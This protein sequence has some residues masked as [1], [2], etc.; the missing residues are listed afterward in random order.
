MLK[1]V[2]PSYPGRALLP[3]YLHLP[4][5]LF[6]YLQKGQLLIHY[7]RGRPSR[8]FKARSKTRSSSKARSSPNT[9]SGSNASGVRLRESRL[10][11][12][13][14]RRRSRR[15]Q[16]GMRALPQV[17]AHEWSPLLQK[18]LFPILYWRYPAHMGFCLLFGVEDSRRRVLWML[19][20]G[21]EKEHC[22]I[23]GILI[24]R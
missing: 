13:I 2:L 4:H 10:V 12:F 11:R 21:Y 17:R 16:P 5:M 24:C 3:Y 1:V 8:W 14:R 7:I 15:N 23:L 19:A 18:G 20:N 6:L 22:S 9:I